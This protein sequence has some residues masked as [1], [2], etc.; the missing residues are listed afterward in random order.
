MS[1]LYCILTGFTT[2]G[3]FNSLRTTGKKRPISIVELIKN[4]RNSA[5]SIKAADVNKYFKL[6]DQGMFFL[7]QDSTHLSAN[8]LSRTNGKDL[9]VYCIFTNGLISVLEWQAHACSGYTLYISICFLHEY[10]PK[11]TGQS[12]PFCTQYCI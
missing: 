9:T 8:F 7:M 4:A 10:K 5:K 2:D 6:N 12:L 3:E 1:I 11:F